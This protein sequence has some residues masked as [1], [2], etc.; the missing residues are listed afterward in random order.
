MINTNEYKRIFTDLEIQNLHNFVN[1]IDPDSLILLET[2][3]KGGK[4]KALVLD[5]KNH[6]TNK[7]SNK[8]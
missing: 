8:K 3:E 5:I 7:E 6:Y 2:K 1:S 4:T